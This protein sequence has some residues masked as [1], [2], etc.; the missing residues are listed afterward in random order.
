M[1]RNWRLWT[2]LR[3]P[4]LIYGD[5][6]AAVQDLAMEEGALPKIRGTTPCTVYRYRCFGAADRAGRATGGRAVRN[7]S[8][9]RIIRRRWRVRAISAAA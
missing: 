2:R 3:H 7:P 1:G 6:V 9:S 5:A 4:H 8:I